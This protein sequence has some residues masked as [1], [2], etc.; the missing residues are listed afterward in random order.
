MML[1]TDYPELFCD[2]V[3]KYLNTDCTVHR[4]MGYLSHYKK[5]SMEEVAD[6]ILITIAM[7]AKIKQDS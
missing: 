7:N 1:Y 5:L 4:M 3:A 6:E 2:E